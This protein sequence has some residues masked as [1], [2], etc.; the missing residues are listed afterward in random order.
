MEGIIWDSSLL[1]RMVKGTTI[2]R[3]GG[4]SSYWKLKREILNRTYFPPP[5]FICLFVFHH[6]LNCTF[7][8]LSMR[9]RWAIFSRLWLFFFKNNISQKVIIYLSVLWCFILVFGLT[10]KFQ[11]KEEILRGSR[12]TFLPLTIC[13]RQSWLEWMNGLEV[14]L[15]FSV[16]SPHNGWAHADAAG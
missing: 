15:G 3:L 16:F 4:S 12:A 1:W 7:M 13:P 8:E 2:T 5:K 6:L 14:Q 10:E 9:L 11:C